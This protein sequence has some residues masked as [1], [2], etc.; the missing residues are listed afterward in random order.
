MTFEAVSGP[1]MLY[2]RRLSGLS[3]RAAVGLLILL[4]D[5]LVQEQCYEE[6][7]V[8]AYC[9]WDSSPSELTRILLESGWIIE[10]DGHLWLVEDDWEWL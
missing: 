6:N 5:C 8:A 4:R 1:K 10:T 7:R 9:D 2:F 3:R